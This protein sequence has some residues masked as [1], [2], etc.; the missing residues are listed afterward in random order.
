MSMLTENRIPGE[1]G[2]L[3]FPDIH[4]VETND[5]MTTKKQATH[6]NYHQELRLGFLSVTA[7]QTKLPCEEDIQK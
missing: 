4:A 6:K 7:R 3:C 5:Q 2:G 1:D